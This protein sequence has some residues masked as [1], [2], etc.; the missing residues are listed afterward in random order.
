M[1][2]LLQR[3][4]LSHLKFNCGLFAGQELSRT[5]AQQGT[6]PIDASSATLMASQGTTATSMYGLAANTQVIFQLRGPQMELI[7]TEFMTNNNPL[8]KQ[9][10]KTQDGSSSTTVSPAWAL[11]PQLAGGLGG[12]TE[13][14][15]ISESTG[16]VTSKE[17]TRTVSSY[18]SGNS[19]A[20]K[21]FDNGAG[22][23][24]SVDTVSAGTPE[25]WYEYWLTLFNRSST[26]SKNY[27]VTTV[28]ATRDTQPATKSTSEKARNT[29]R[30]SAT[31]SSSPVTNTYIR[32]TMSTTLAVLA[33]L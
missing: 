15:S 3:G 16:M 5:T 12:S 14:A 25:N 6:L 4:D 30:I 9:T 21:V 17:S 19:G 2:I 28:Q 26:A 22:V 7:P 33:G 27:G 20:D 29:T 32:S 1:N 23:M 24:S 18:A 8:D 13:Q 31:Y 11:R 10:T